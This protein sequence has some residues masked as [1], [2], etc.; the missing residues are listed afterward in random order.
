MISI[1]E[2]GEYSDEPYELHDERDERDDAHCTTSNQDSPQPPL[3]QQSLEASL[4]VIA[5]VLFKHG[6]LAVLFILLN[7]SIFLKN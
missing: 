7:F 6:T 2:E 5:N 3:Q 1:D 4:N